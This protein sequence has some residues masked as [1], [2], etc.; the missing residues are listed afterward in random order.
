LALGFSFKFY[1]VIYLI[2]L[3]IKQPNSKNALKIVLIFLAIVGII[4]IP[5][6]I[7]NFSGWFFF[8]KLNSARL[9]NFDSIWTA[10]RYFLPYLH[11]NAQRINVISS[12]LLASFYF[13]SVWKF[14]KE[15]FLKLCFIVTL[16]FLIFNKV[17][18][19]QYILWLLPFFVLFQPPKLYWFY[20]LEF[21]NLIVLFIA[22]RW[23]FIEQ[24]FSY[25]FWSM[26]FIF[27][28]HLILIYLLSNIWNKK[29]A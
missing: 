21:S 28:R 19:P 14:R 10:I 17:F 18:S 4:N 15:S 20:L 1:P 27:L 2:P 6:M 29:T 11:N 3:L 13:Y 5:F 9:P 8:F 24:S 16:G 12:A 7:A 25:M 22:L 26:P 23:F